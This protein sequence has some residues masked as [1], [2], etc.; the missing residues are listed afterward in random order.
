M[1][2]VTRK[3]ILT[4]AV[5]DWQARDVVPADMA[6]TLLQDIEANA[7]QFAFRNILILLAVICLGFAAMTFVAAN[8]DDMSRPARVG[9]I[10]AAMW[11]FWGTAAILHAKGSTWF[12]QVFSLG[13][14]AM[15]GAGIMLISQIYHIQGSSKDDT[16]LWAMGTL[17]AAGL[18][19]SPP[20]LALSMALF[21][22][23]TWLEP[24]MFTW[25]EPD[26]AWSFPLYI[27]VAAG[28]AFWM[29]SRF[30]AHLIT[31]A[32]L[33]W[34][35]PTALSLLE[36]RS[37]TFAMA[38]IG[39]GFVVLSLSLLSD[40]KH[41]LLRGFERPLM[42][43]VL[44][45]LGLILCVWFARD[46]ITWANLVSVDLHTQAIPP[47]IVACLLTLGLGAYAYRSAHPNTY[48]VIATAVFCVIA[49]V[50]MIAFGGA[51][52][53]QFAVLLAGSIWILRMGWRLDFRP[54]TVLGF[55]AFGAVMIW[56][57]ADTIGTLLGT[58]V[59]YGG[60]GIL[61]LIGVFVLPRI[62]KIGA[63]Q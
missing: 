28:L 5:T 46:N 2:N 48:D 62:A 37:A 1:I 59:F 34:A 39:L 60:I 54:L 12:A 32:L 24:S 58:S 27:A 21:T 16:W 8:W 47:A 57:Y 22:T 30:N 19:R 20:A 41:G 36:D 63:S 25:R 35:V 40:R 23:W 9:V 13:A 51:L 43:Y 52:I 53:L 45:A 15:F 31:L 29:R 56:I 55:I 26:F 49:Y 10:F 14:C 38:I 11:G 4:A 44:A 6:E 18:T 7:T 3:S 33:G 61:L 50:T 17:L 42:F